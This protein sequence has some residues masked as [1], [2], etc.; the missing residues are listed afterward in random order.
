MEP[1]WKTMYLTMMKATEEAMNLLI[2]A[3]RECEAL[4]VEAGEKTAA[5]GTEAVQAA[6]RTA[7]I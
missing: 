7:G 3:Q 6:E 4:Y 2:A 5:A 1:D